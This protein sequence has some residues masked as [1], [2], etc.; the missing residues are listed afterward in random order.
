M[1]WNSVVVVLT[2]RG[3]IEAVILLALFTLAALVVIGLGM[4]T[5]SD[6]L[7]QV[8]AVVMWCVVAGVVV[9]GVWML[10]DDLLSSVFL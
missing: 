4:D 3:L 10:G 9:L 6:R 5:F 2:V 8:M 1:L 7:F